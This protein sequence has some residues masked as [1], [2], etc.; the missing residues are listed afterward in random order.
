MEKE[1]AEAAESSSDEDGITKDELEA[2][3][4]TV[5]GKITIIKMDHNLK[6]NRR[7]KSKLRNVNEMA[8]DMKAKGIDL[9]EESFAARA[10]S[11]KTLG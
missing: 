3:V 9:N 11:R 6:K 1:Q 7:A 8:A 4:K 10:K 2:A 5:R